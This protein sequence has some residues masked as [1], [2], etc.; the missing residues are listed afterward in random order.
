MSHE[1]SKTLTTLQNAN[2]PFINGFDESDEHA[3]GEI[4]YDF[5]FLLSQL[6]NS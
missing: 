2:R 6:L 1:D 4:S 5:T 3:A